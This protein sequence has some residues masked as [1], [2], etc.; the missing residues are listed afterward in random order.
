[1]LLRELHHRVKNN[2]QIIMS[3]L[4]LQRPSY[5]DE[6]DGRLVEKSIKRVQSMALV[7][8]H[9][10]RAETLTK[11]D[12]QSYVDGMLK[13]ILRG[14]PHWHSGIEITTDLDGVE[15]DLEEAV[16]IGLVMHELIDNALVHAFPG[17]REGRVE[18]HGECKSG[19]GCRITIRD[20]G[21]GLDESVDPQRAESLG[22]LLVQ[23]LVHQVEG[24]LDF[25][26]NGGTEIVL[27]FPGRSCGASRWAD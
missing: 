27:E 6:I 13:E 9:L 24:R 26:G 1:V 17:W 11:V 10:Y 23:T 16:P 14:S 18:I 20:D 7:H 12:L 15:L 2:M 4:N 25:S 3:L 19:A 5:R 22:F 8:D 21:V